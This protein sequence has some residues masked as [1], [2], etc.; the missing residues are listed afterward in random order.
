MNTDIKDITKFPL[1]LSVDD[2]AR[3]MS[4]SRVKAYNLAHSEG[5]PCKQIDRRMVIP[6]DAFF[7]WLNSFNNNIPVQ[8]GKK[9][10]AASGN[11]QTE[12]L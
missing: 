3:I 9:L 1:V 5:F 6:R 7:Y 10:A 8:D 4:I 11:T 2:V 12:V